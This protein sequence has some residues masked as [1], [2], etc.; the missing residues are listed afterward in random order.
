MDNLAISTA[1]L[2]QDGLA[3]AKAEQF[4]KASTS[5]DA[6]SSCLNA[7]AKVVIIAAAL[8]IL[9]AVFASMQLAGALIIALPVVTV[10][11]VGFFY[12]DK[13]VFVLSKIDFNSAASRSGDLGG[14][15]YRDDTHSGRRSGSYGGP[16]GNVPFGGGTY[17]GPGHTGTQG[18]GRGGQVPFGG[19]HQRAPGS[20]HTGFGGGL[21]RP[22]QGGHP[23]PK[24]NVPFGQRPPGD[25]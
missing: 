24:S 1:H 21:A 18:S 4:A 11:T 19:G 25:Q 17:H 9:I 12:S 13:L 15:H 22:P 23:P 14:R 6:V 16:D 3:R 2:S 20:S 7:V 5:K 10:G 8:F